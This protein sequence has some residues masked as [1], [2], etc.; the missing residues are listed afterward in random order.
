MID[1]VRSIQAHL[2]PDLLKPQYRGS[3][4]PYYGH[5]YVASEALY[6][7]LG[8]EDSGWVP[9]RARDGNGIVHWWLEKDDQ[10][11]DVTR[12]QYDAR[13]LEPPYAQGR[14]AGFLTKQPSRRA[15]TLLDRLP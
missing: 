14:R 7:A 3:E 5:C 12:E 13:D 15:R 9:A 11:L 1:L 8:G 2:T 6:H 4:I 10:I